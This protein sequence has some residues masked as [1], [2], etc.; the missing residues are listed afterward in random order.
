MRLGALRV[1]TTPGEVRGCFAA[2]RVVCTRRVC[3][4]VLICVCV[5]VRRRVSEG[6]IPLFEGACL[7]STAL[8][9]SI[10]MPDTLSHTDVGDDKLTHHKYQT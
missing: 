1:F 10:K 2:W 8:A 7:V 3:V 9:D 4:L 5:G 6:R